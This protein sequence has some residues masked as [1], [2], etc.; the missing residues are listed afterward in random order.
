MF[1]LWVAMERQLVLYAQGRNEIAEMP[2]VYHAKIAVR[3][4]TV[5]ICLLAL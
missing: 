5:V 4:A 1:T 2:E 3:I